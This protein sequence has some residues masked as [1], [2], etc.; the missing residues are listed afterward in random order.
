MRGKRNRVWGKTNP[1]GSTSRGRAAGASGIG[2]SGRGGRGGTL[3]LRAGSR[4]T[5]G[6]R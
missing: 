6:F 5:G 3:N 1:A 4:R 2:R